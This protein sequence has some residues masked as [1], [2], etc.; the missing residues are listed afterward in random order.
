M[1]ATLGRS[2]IARS[3]LHVAPIDVPTTQDPFFITSADL[4]GDGRRDMVVTSYL[5]FMVQVFLNRASNPFSAPAAYVAGGV[6]G[7]PVTRSPPY[8]MD[9]VEP[10]ADD[11]GKLLGRE[12]P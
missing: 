8:V 2:T 12:R 6:S 1:Q 7:D 5:G 4:N 3:P 11:R 9:Y 10:S